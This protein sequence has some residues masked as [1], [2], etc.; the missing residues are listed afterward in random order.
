[1]TNILPAA[2]AQ[3]ERL[4]AHALETT[5]DN[6]RGTMIAGANAI[7]YDMIR[8]GALTTDDA[9]DMSTTVPR[10]RRDDAL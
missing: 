7:L 10:L 4:K 3:I 1:M 8:Q 9:D 2:L 6:L 5:D